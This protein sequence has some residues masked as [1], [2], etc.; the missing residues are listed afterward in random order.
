MKKIINGRIYDTRTSTKV[1][2]DSA[3]RSTADF[4]YW[5]ETLYRKRSGEY[6]LHG[7]GGAQSRYAES[8]GYM[9]WGWGEQIIP[10]TYEKAAKWAEEH[11]S[12]DEY[13]KIFGEVPEDDS[14]TVVH[15]A[16]SVTGAEKLR[17]YASE[18]GITMGAY[19]E[20]L[21]P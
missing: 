16:I 9:E 5:R 18:R 10:L 13:E 6:F 11:L 4:D 8:C 14:R 19:V 3:N 20:S 7:E 1:G 15:L 17:R 21:L 12:A 2:V